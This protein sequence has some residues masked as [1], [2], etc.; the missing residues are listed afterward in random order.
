MKGSLDFASINAAALAALPAVLSGLLPGGKIIG[1]EYMVLN[2]T[3]A[4]HRLGSFKINLRSGQ[5]ADFATGDRG[6]D[7]IS[8]VAYTEGASQ[9]EAARMLARMIGINVGGRR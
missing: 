5:W 9:G 7:P 2:P 6:G 3:R 8:L 1:G 4:D